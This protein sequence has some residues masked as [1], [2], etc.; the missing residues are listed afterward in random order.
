[1]AI[2]ISSS[3]TVA[4]SFE[5][6]SKVMIAMFYVVPLF[7]IVGVVVYRIKKLPQKCFCRMMHRNTR[8]EEQQPQV[9][10][11]P[12]RIVHPEEYGLLHDTFSEY[13]L[14]CSDTEFNEIQH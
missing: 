7:Y 12:D 1:M 2:V 8:E 9:D 14:L 3:Q 5:D 11:L 13:Q 6:T 4:Q 10:S